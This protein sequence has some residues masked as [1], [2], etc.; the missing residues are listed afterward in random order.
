[1]RT[2]IHIMTQPGE[3]MM[4]SAA[5]TLSVRRNED[6]SLIIFDVRGG[7]VINR[8]WTPTPTADT[9]DFFINDTLKPAFSICYPDLFSGK[10]YPFIAPLCGNQLGGFYC[11]MPIPFE[12]WLQDSN[13]GGKKSSFTRFSTG[14]MKKVPKSDLSALNWTPEEKEA[15]NKINELW[16]K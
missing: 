12:K 15:L 14:F 13:Q 8:I 3:M 7:G 2:D 11:Y 6:G 10:K 9:L 1:M 16:N 5:G 4:V